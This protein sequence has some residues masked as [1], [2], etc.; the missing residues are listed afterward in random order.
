MGQNDAGNLLDGGDGRLGG[1]EGR[2]LTLAQDQEIAAGHALDRTEEILAHEL[3]VH[4]RQSPETPA[5]KLFA[6]LKRIAEKTQ[7]AADA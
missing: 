2:F 7:I 1:G 4:H 3:A 5:V 6:E